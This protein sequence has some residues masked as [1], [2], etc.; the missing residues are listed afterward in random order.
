MSISFNEIKEK[1]HEILN[2]KPGE[3]R[4]HLVWKF[5]D[6]IFLRD[7]IDV[8]DEIEDVLIDLAH[9]LEYYNSDPKL[10][11][12]NRIF[13]GDEELELKI[14]TALQKIEVLRNKT[15]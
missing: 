9:V 8:S 1:L 5:D 4:E 14:N 15:K 10:R 13:F 2:E 11:K 6:I 3:I 12:E 7:D